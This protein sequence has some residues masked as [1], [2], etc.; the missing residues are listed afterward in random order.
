MPTVAPA[1][2][3]AVPT[4]QPN[5]R[6]MRTSLVIPLGA[7]IVAVRNNNGPQSA[8]FLAQ[9]NDAAESVLPV[10]AS[11]TSKPG[12]ALHSAIVNVRSHPGNLAALEQDR[13]SLL[14]DIP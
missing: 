6:G 2:P 12:N 13:L 1:I 9:F 10:I 3:T 8:A 5:Y 7:L 14:R 11:D 4:P